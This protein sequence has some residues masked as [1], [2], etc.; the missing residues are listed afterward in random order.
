MY[1]AAAVTDSNIV[2]I[3]ARQSLLVNV[4]SVES[5][6]ALSH[7]N[8]VERF[9][10]LSDIRSFGYRDNVHKTERIAQLTA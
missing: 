6:M 3:N 9:I 1:Y 5:M 2:K 8:S 7:K 4:K 10:M